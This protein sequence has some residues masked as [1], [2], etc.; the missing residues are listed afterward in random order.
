MAARPASRCSSLRLAITIA[1]PRRANSDAMALPRPVPPPV[2]STVV[3]SYVP[4]GS[5]LVPS[6]GG[7]GNGIGQ[8]PV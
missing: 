8:L 7:S 5:A 1:A 3:P 4:G 6:G 2:T